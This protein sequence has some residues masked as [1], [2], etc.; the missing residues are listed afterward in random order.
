M[1]NVNKSEVQC[2]LCSKILKNPV[3]LPCQCTICHAHLTD[4]SVKDG[5]IACV[6]CGENFVVKSIQ[7]KEN[8][9]AKLILDADGHLNPEEKAVKSEIQRLFNEFLNIYEQLQQEHAAFELSSFDHFAEIKRQ[10]DIQ[11]EKLKEKID[12]ISLTMIRKVEQ[13]A[14]F[15]K[16]KLEENRCFKEFNAETETKHFEDQFRQVDLSIESVQQLQ[17]KY[18]ANVKALQDSMNELQ[19]LSKQMNKCSFLAEKDLDTSSFGA[20]NLMNLSRYLASSSKDNTIKL[21]DFETKECIRTIEGHAAKIDCIDVLSNGQLVSGSK[22]KLLKVWNPKDGACL[23]TMVCSD[24]IRRL[25]VLSDNRVACASI[26]K[27]HVW[28]LNAETCIQTLVGHTDVIH[29]LIA[30]PGETLLSCSSDKTIKMWNLND[31]SCV[32]TLLG[33]TGFVLSLILL[34]DGHFASGSA[35]NTI[36]IW[37]RN[38]GECIRT[39]QGH[40][41]WILALESSDTF[42]LISCSKDKSIK[43][44]NVTS[45]KC[46]RTLLEHN[47]GVYR[48]RMYSIDL[49]ASGSSDKSIK[50]W[51]LS[52]GNC[53]TTLNGHTDLISSIIFI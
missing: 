4:G 12:E 52:N 45:G 21:W 26:M 20:L 14:I 50:L 33:H 5:L 7:L 39:L 10:I 42:D 36:K 32:Q 13:H 8:K 43:I 30:L 22:D 44:W 37:K 6:P 19:F 29:C 23:K 49:L 2:Q 11:R 40:T 47:G 18:E 51:D 25:I 9:Y 3:N 53:I 28:D 35:D 48:I 27:I 1:V 38:N 46:I 31:S 17:T 16:E 34:K 41:N 24:I 15:Y